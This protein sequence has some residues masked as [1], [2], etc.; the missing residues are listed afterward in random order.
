MH[1][2][3]FKTHEDLPTARL[4]LLYFCVLLTVQGPL[5]H[6]TLTYSLGWGLLLNQVG[7]MLLPVGLICGFWKMDVGTLFPLRAVPGKQWRWIIL[8]TMAIILASDLALALTDYLLPIPPH[9]QETLNQLLSARGTGEFLKKLI[10]FCIL[11]AIAEE[12]YFRGFCQTSLTHRIGIRPAIV[13]TALL[14]AL[15][16]GNVWYL[17]LYFGLGLFLGWLF[18]K[19]GSLW[20]PIIA[21]FLNNTWTYISHLMGWEVI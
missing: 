7:L 6:L 9:I 20:P 5:G 8:A 17:H 11:P 21:H 14:F 1:G 4:I 18:E 10:L 15:A 16:H 19:T 12:V 13:L 2:T 3:W